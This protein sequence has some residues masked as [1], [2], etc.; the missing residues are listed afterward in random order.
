M[1]ALPV[2]TSNLFN[3]IAEQGALFAFMLLVMLVMSIVIRTLYKRNIEL[4]DGLHKALTDST[5][6]INNNTISNNSLTRQI[7]V[8]NNVRGS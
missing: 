7:E 8:M 2:D 6:A 3:K 5:V 4:G 1:E